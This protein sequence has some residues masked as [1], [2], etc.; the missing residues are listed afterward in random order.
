[1]ANAAVASTTATTISGRK[2][3][4]MSRDRRWALRWSY[5][6]LILFAIFFLT[7]PIYMLITSLKTSAEIS[8]ATNPWWVLDPT[9]GNYIELLG[10]SQYLMFFRNSAIVSVV[11]VAI[12]MLI[13][14]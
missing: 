3:G 12:T 8:T 9:L 11:V 13:S 1:M 7:P 14:V 6:F 5:F 2:Y 10:S 4:S